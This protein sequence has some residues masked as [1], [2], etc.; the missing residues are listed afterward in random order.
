MGLYW[1]QEGC[2][3]FCCRGF[4]FGRLLL[5]LFGLSWLARPADHHDEEEVKRFKE[6]RRRFRNKMRSAV[7]ELLAEDGSEA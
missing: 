2:G 6:R 4:S 5:A 3:L 7:R 1:T